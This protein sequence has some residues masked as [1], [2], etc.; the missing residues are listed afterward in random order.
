MESVKCSE[1]SKSVIPRHQIGV[2]ISAP[3]TPVTGRNLSTLT[4]IQGIRSRRS[5]SATCDMNF[6]KKNQA[7]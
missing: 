6:C 4:S 3:G 7:R 2:Y 1:R 5:Q